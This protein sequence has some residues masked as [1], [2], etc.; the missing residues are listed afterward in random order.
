M[1]LETNLIKNVDLCDES[2]KALKEEDVKGIMFLDEY[3]QHH[4]NFCI[5]ESNIQIPHDLNQNSN[6]IPLRN[7]KEDTKLHL[8]T[9]KTTDSLNYPKE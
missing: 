7:K 6:N 5:T 9:Q 1:Y 2:H 4:Q 3:N 8:E